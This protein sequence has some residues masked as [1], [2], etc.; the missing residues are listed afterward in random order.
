MQAYVQGQMADSITY[1]AGISACRQ[2]RLTDAI[3]YPAVISASE[4][5]R[6]PTQLGQCMQKGPDY[7][8]A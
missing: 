3:T 5:T 6:S 7:G 2:G 1:T 4:M 8:E